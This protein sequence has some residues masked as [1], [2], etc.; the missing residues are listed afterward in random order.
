MISEDRNSKYFNTRAS[1]R[2][3]QNRILELR[4]TNGVLVLGEGNLSV[5]VRDYYKNL[6]LSLESTDVEL[7]SPLILL[8]PTI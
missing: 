4:S 8:L 2:F 7:P 5:M 3:R 6:F 1:Q